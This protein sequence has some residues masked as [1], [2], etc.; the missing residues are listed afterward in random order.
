VRIRRIEVIEICLPI[1]RDARW[2]AL[3]T[4]L[5][6]YALV[7]LET[8]DGLVG[9]GEA[10][11]LP[12]WGG[13]YGRRYGEDPAIVAHVIERYLAP[14]LEAMDPFDICSIHEAMNRRIRGYPYTKAAVD[15]ALHDLIGKALG[16]P[17]CRLLG[18]RY[19]ADVPLA[20]MIGLMDEHDALEE[21]KD[22]VSEGV[23]AL[24]VKGG[25]NAERD[26]RLI[27]ALRQTLGDEVHLRLDA[28]Q[29]YPDVFTAVSAVRAM[30]PSRLD[31]I[32][33]PVEGLAGLGEVRRAV[34]TM[35]MADESCWS[36][37]DGLDVIRQRA[38]DAVSIYV[39]K[40]GG[41]FWAA[42]LASVCAAAGI[43]CD[44]NGSLET[45]VGTAA[46]LHLAGSQP[47]IRLPCVICA[48]A[49]RETAAPGV[50][51]RYYLDDVIAAPLPYHDGRLRVPES[52]GL[53]IALDEDKIA[54]Y[55]VRV[56]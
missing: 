31:V 47:A 48:S 43:A 27:V 55:T 49:P 18:G 40:A 19:R 50:A 46:N 12:D 14:V 42:R 20:H 41:L 34:G 53:G 54:A 35:V 25:E 11:V 9:V 10:T 23:R 39:A 21:S 2:R 37:E 44:V 51:C 45:G 30:E 16:L 32:E 15:M 3:E 56:R 38:A 52:P 4:R 5:G 33:Q 36:L 28:N 29:G 13:D 22:A 1:R 8:A 6:N 7:K 24:Q 26:I 17:V